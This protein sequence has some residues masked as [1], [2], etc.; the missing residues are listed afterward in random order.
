MKCPNCKREVQRLKKYQIY[1]CLCGIK[2]M[3]IEISKNLILVNLSKNR[4]RLND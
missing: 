4:G 2:L 3:C 1:D